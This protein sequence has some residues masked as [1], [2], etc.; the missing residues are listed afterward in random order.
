MPGQ[1]DWLSCCRSSSQRGRG[2]EWCAE[3]LLDRP[4]GAGRSRAKDLLGAM[5]RREELKSRE[6]RDASGIKELLLL[7]RT[8]LD[9]SGEFVVSSHTMFEKQYRN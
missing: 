4:W 6:D 2:D 1:A 3:R 8:V 5:A 9:I 7:L